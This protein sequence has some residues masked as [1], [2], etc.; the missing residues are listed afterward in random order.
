MA[1]LFHLDPSQ[2]TSACV[3]VL[4][5]HLFFVSDFFRTWLRFTA[6]GGRTV[7]IL[8]RRQ[9]VWRCDGEGEDFLVGEDLGAEIQGP[10]CSPSDGQEQGLTSVCRFCW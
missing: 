2:F 9:C 8:G 1:V 10:L 7:W 6:K 3:T 4:G 5:S